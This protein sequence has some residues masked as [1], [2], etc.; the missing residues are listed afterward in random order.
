[1]WIHAENLLGNYLGH[2]PWMIYGP[3]RITRTNLDSSLGILYAPGV[4]RVGQVAPHRAAS[5]TD[6]VQIRGGRGK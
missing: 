1:M 6:L 2:D 4:T 3:I 5:G